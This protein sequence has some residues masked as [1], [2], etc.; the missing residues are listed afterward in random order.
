M[1]LWNHALFQRKFARESQE[2]K[3]DTFKNF[4]EWLDDTYVTGIPNEEEWQQIMEED[5]AYNYTAEPDYH[6]RHDHRDSRGGFFQED[7]RE[8]GGECRDERDNL[9]PYNPEMHTFERS[10]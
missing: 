4:R 3:N 6:E 5:E 1:I 7:D 8:G 9:S 2:P 10:C